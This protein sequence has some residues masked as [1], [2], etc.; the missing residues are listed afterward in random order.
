MSEGETSPLCHSAHIR[1]RPIPSPTV[2]SFRTVGC[3]DVYASIHIPT[4]LIVPKLPHPH[5]TLSID[6]EHD[7]P[8]ALFSTP[9]P[10]VQ[11]FSR[12]L[13]TAGIFPPCLELKNVVA[14]D[15][16]G[17]WYTVF[18]LHTVLI[19]SRNWPRENFRH[20]LY[21]SWGLWTRTP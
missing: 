13:K 9:G 21:V 7:H 8:H 3:T 1:G 18:S 11:S 4:I 6:D 16:F 15:E 10:F 2:P 14:L 12:S 20:S 19:Y 5:N 17:A